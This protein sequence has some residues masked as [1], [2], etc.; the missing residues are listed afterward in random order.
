M[1]YEGPDL[2][3]LHGSLPSN[4]LEKNGSICHVNPVM[5]S[6]IDDIAVEECLGESFASGLTAVLFASGLAALKVMS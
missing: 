6:F 4:I 5:F 1:S 2:S 3:S